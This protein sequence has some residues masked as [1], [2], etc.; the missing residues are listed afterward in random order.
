MLYQHACVPGVVETAVPLLNRVTQV[1]IQTESQ[2]YQDEG[3]S[4]QT[5]PATK[6]WFRNKVA[7]TGDIL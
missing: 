3:G 7:R 2:V 5:A 6:R 4:E 1:Q